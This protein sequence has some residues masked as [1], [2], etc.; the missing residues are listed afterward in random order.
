M[1]AK[2]WLAPEFTCENR[3]Q[4]HSVPHLDRV[5]LDGRWR[6]Q[7][8]HTPEEELGPDWSEQQ[9]PGCWTMQDTW[10]R[11]HYTNVQ[12]PFP[13]QPLDIPSVNP[14]GVYERD[15]RLDPEWLKSRR[16]VLHVGAAESVLIAAVNGRHVGVS[17]DSHL[18]AEF[19]VTEL[20]HAGDNQI[21]LRVVKW[22]DA[23][24]IEDQDQWWHGGITRPVFLYATPLIHF[25]DVRVNAGLADDLATGTF[26]VVADIDW[27]GA[28]ERGW[29]VEA[30]LGELSAVAAPVPTADHGDVQV[31]RAD[32]ATLSRHVFDLVSKATPSSICRC[33]TSGAGRRNSLP[34]THSI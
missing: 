18:A 14:T 10:D 8:L 19:D 27:S 7:L 12:M 29:T 5:A 31:S 24:W 21:S 4:M 11:P 13:G 20:V 26:E 32:S 15:F 1:I 2:P 22:S 33:L 17:K 34:C 25:A 23:T 3:L 6:F 30:T 28:P 16:V 9:V